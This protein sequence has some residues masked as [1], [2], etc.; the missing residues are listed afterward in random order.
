MKEKGGLF[1]KFGKLAGWIMGGTILG[2]LAITGG[3]HLV[4]KFKAKSKQLKEIDQ[5]K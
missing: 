5:K 3:F 2:G 4:K 1:M